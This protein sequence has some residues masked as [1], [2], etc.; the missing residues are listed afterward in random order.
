MLIVETFARG[1]PICT[2]HQR[3][4]PWAPWRSQLWVCLERA[5]HGSLQTP[6]SDSEIHGASP[7]RSAVSAH[8]KPHSTP[9]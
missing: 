1:Q 7:A 4:P 6:A 5:H 8:L 2:P 3:G 9:W